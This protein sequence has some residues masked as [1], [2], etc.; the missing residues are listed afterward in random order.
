[1]ICTLDNR[2]QN[3]VKMFRK[4]RAL[5]LLVAFHPR[6]PWE[7]AK[8]SGFFLSFFFPFVFCLSIFLS[9]SFFFNIGFLEFLMF[10]LA[11]E[12]S[13]LRAVLQTVRKFFPYLYLIIIILVSFAADQSGKRTL[14]DPG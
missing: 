1:M 12:L 6:L 9:S 2:P 14:S 4:I 13:L 11:P 7:T 3:D 5:I 8:Q 10:T